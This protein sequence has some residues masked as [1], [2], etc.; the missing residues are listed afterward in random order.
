MAS[1]QQIKRS[2]QSEA[3][4][5]QEVKRWEFN[6]S[7]L[8]ERFKLMDV[9]TEGQIES[10]IKCPT[11][12]TELVKHRVLC[13]ELVCV[14]M[15]GLV[16]LKWEALPKPHDLFRD[17]LN[18]AIALCTRLNEDE[19]KIQWLQQTKVAASRYT[20]LMRCDIPDSEEYTDDCNMYDVC[21]M[22]YPKHPGHIDDPC[23][24]NAGWEPR[25][26]KALYEPE[27]Y[28]K[29]MKDQGLVETSRVVAL[30]WVKSFRHVR[31]HISALL[32]IADTVRNEETI[33]RAILQRFT[34]AQARP[35]LQE[36]F[37]DRGLVHRVARDVDVGA[38]AHH[39]TL[40]SDEGAMLSLMD[41]PRSGSDYDHSMRCSD[42]M[43][44]VDSDLRKDSTFIISA[45]HK[46]PKLYWML[47]PH[48]K[49]N[50]LIAVAF[51]ET[52]VPTAHLAAL[53]FT[54]LRRSLPF[55]KQLLSGLHDIPGCSPSV[56]YRYFE[57]NVQTN[58]VVVSLAFA[59]CKDET[60]APNR[61]RQERLLLYSLHL[62]MFSDPNFI[63]KHL[64]PEHEARTAFGDFLRL[65][66]LARTLY[67]TGELVTH[68]KQ[69]PSCALRGVTPT[70]HEWLKRFHPTLLAEA[71]A[72]I[73][74]CD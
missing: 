57:E 20:A 13:T 18:M 28:H 67:R 19:A 74:A 6:N 41:P 64:L 15:K 42:I 5:D 12:A 50:P 34:C 2:Q 9:L 56:C 58:P 17:M 38:I 46:C 26:S 53:K 40:N 4:R 10:R 73:A 66:V 54:T 22:L 14:V 65:V 68:T 27:E 1:H 60:S 37:Q 32:V 71:E 61:R 29:L 39:P 35:Y 62:T 23:Y 63:C 55:A 69:D 47:E 24:F 31:P 48:E 30:Q 7:A 49:T 16:P 51:L 25:L 33:V 21:Q 44:L 45:I 36:A 72:K 59:R 43:L 8:Q 52:K 70:E 11:A 3:S